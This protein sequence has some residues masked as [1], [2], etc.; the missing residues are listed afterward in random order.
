M[1]GIT[2]TT[3]TPIVLFKYSWNGN[4]KF[5]KHINNLDALPVGISFM[6]DSKIFVFLQKQSYQDLS[7]ILIINS[8]G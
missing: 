3:Y 6:T 1:G 4:F 2:E 7:Y 8:L 5:R